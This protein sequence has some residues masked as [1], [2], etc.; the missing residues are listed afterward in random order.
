M[1]TANGNVRHARIVR[2][3]IQV[4]ICALAFWH[5]LCEMPPS[6]GQFDKLGSTRGPSLNVDRLMPTSAQR[7]TIGSVG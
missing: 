7:R 5:W 1:T 6:G 2:S 4:G 3:T